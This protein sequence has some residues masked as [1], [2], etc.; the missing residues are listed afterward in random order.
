MATSIQDAAN[1]DKIAKPYQ[2]RC[3]DESRCGSGGP[4]DSAP[5]RARNQK[6]SWPL[7]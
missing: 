5:P 2:I 6:K 1:T 3:S 4:L 7:A